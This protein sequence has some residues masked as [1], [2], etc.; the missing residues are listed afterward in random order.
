MSQTQTTILCAYTRHTNGI[1][2]YVLHSPT[3]EGFDELLVHLDRVFGD[4]PADEQMRSLIDFRNGFPPLQY[5]FRQTQGFL[6][7]Y[8]NRTYGSKVAY[9]YTSSTLISM[10]K[11]FISLFR[12]NNSD[13]RFFRVAERET[14]L[15]WLAEE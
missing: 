4:S 14:A 6:K 9:L 3:R 15:A 11:S 10:M 1:H 2:E 8:P 7:K 13:N 12:L 5:A